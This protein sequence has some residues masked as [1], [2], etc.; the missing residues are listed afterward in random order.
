M[1]LIDK[2]WDAIKDL[3]PVEEFDDPE[4]KGGRPYRKA[5]HVLDGVL[6]VLR[7]GAPWKELPR[8]YPPYQTCHRRFMNWNKEGVLRAVL[9]KLAEDLKRRGKVD[10]TEAY[11]DGSHSRAKKGVLMLTAL[12]VAKRPRSWQWS[13]AMVFLSWPG[14]QVVQSM[15]QSSS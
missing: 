4:P 5:R 11:I 14:L 15:K 2:Q 3:F 1:D 8:Q 6:W 9:Q 10:F 7:T 13:T 12:E